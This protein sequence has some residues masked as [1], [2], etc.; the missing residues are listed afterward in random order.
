MNQ[1]WKMSALETAQKVKAGELSATEVTRST[2]QRIDA[3]NPQLNAII[4]E[5]ADEAFQAA[6]SVDARIANGEPA[7]DLAGVPVTVKVNIDQTGHATTNGVRIQEHQIAQ[8]DSPVVANF[9]KAGAII[10]GRTNTPA[11]SL[12]WFTRNS[13]HGHTLNPRSASITPGGSS[14][15]A[16]A[17]VASGMG[18]IGHG[19]D[20]GGSIR[21]PAYAC[22]LHGLRPTI[23]RIPAWNASGPDRHIGAQLM[24]V[25]GPIARTMA[26]IELGYNALS[27]QD[28]RDPWWVP[29]ATDLPA[30]PK[31]AGLC[32]RPDNM[33]VEDSVIDALKDAGK[34][35][36]D[37]GW[38]VDE[39]DCPGFSEAAK[40]QLQ[41]WVS[42]FTMGGAAAVEK[43]QDPDALFV[44]R[45]LSET[46]GDV[47][48]N[49]VMLALQNRV[50][51]IRQWQLFMQDYPVLIC[52]VSGQMPFK[53][54]QDVSSVEAFSE[55]MDAQLTQLGLPILTLP[56]LTVSTGMVGKSPVGVQLISARYREDQL[57]RAGRA[58]ET[59][60]IP[61]SPIDPFP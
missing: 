39:V 34:R 48:L 8:Q 31:K 56:G 21:Y 27:Q 2:L 40:L 61:E 20:I 3:V 44:H 11:F 30:L 5:M 51:L 60:G 59:G 53:D 26:D 32:L 33:Q 43:E 4:D 42:E 57:F 12:R 13:L 50:G 28:F 45:Q 15:G 9:R 46:C 54:L 18:A 14:G 47:D 35:L 1:L 49:S 41:L 36:E 55:I 38:Q 25:S 6:A 23:G 58:I 16:A 24:A 29:I 22:G 52:P 37:A 17:A 7:G 19:T 10:V